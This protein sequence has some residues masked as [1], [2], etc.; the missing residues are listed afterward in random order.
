MS[1]KKFRPTTPGQRFKTN[2]SFEE[3]THKRPHK[4]LL[5]ILKKSGG[6]NNHGHITTRYRGGG[7]KRFYRMID[8][9]RDKQGIP[10][11]VATIEYDPNR[12]ARIALLHYRDGEKRYIIAP[13][14]LK[15]GQEVM[16]GPQAEV[17]VGNCLPLNKMPLGTEIHNIELKPGRGGQIA[18]G[19]GASAQ[20]MAK[21]GQFALIKLP[22]GELRQIPLNCHATIGQVGNVEHEGIS[23]GKAGRFRW[24][25]RRPRVRGVA[26]N[27]VDHPLGGGEGKSSGGRHPCTP[28]GK[29]T[30][31]FKTR[32]KGKGSDRFIVK[33]RG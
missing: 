16:S 14:G 11:K 22:S 18:R 23:L 6:R 31:G 12:G 32:K 30:K 26:K 33:R 27:P 19:A 21:E 28:W 5:V 25:G 20:L 3:I 15:V 29:P 2:S 10:A 7:Q 13:L 8:L 24:L 9:K 1:L 4:P 17:K